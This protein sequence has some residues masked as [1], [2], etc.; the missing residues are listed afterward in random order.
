MGKRVV[1]IGG[2]PAGYEAA[3]QGAAIGAEIILV[4]R[5]KVG[6]TCLNY[7]CIPTKVMVEQADFYHKIQR[8]SKVVAVEGASLSMNGLNEH[9]NAIVQSLVEDVQKK[10][11]GS[12]ATLINGYGIPIDANHV[13]IIHEDDTITEVSCDLIILAT[14][15]KPILLDVEGV[16]NPRV[17]TSKGILSLEK[18]PSSLTV[19]GGGVIGIE[20]AGIYNRLGVQVSVL[21]FENRILPGLDSALGKRL[22]SI[23]TKDGIKVLT[24]AKVSAFTEMNERVQTIYEDKKGVHHIESD[25]VLMAVGRQGDFERTMLENIGVQ[26]DERYVHVD[27]LYLTSVNGIYAIGDVNGISLLAHSAYDQARQL[28]SYVIEGIIPSKRLI[29]S[30]VF[31]Y[32]EIASIGLSE[33]KAVEEGIGYKSERT[34]FGA[35]GKALAIGETVGFVKTLINDEGYLIGC[36]IMGPHASDLLHYASIAMEGNMTLEQLKGIVFA[37]PTLGEI[38]SDNLR[39]Y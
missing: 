38:F 23:L 27:G 39:Q 35:S 29:P 6:G 16:H 37:H 1:I 33:E 31:S 34:L 30:C 8:G 22:K 32:P 13:A 21:E 19:V 5:H 36:H 15:S 3:I 17:L 4:E 9:V 7:G 2:G 14:G 26:C 10:I 12:N 28:M 11:E 24:G 18:L 20:F 25:Y